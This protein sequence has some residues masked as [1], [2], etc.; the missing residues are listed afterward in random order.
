MMKNVNGKLVFGIIVALLLVQAAAQATLTPLILPESSLWQG[1]R[2]YDHEA[3]EGIYAYVEYAV[4]D[5]K[6]AGYHNQMDGLTDGFPNPGDGRYIYAYQVFNY[7]SAELLP[8][9]A[10]QLIGGDSSAAD[11]INAMN[12]G[13]GSIMPIEK[14]PSLKWKFANGV[15]SADK[16]SAFLAFSSDIGPVAGDFKLLTLSNWG[17]DPPTTP[18]PATLAML[19][20]GAVGLLRKRRNN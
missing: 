1:G 15:F 5:T 9:T 11:G 16:H 3:D 18:E 17:E 6:A 12:D 7:G 20:A 13:Q 10:F 19:A 8:I 14:G 2:I 4:Y